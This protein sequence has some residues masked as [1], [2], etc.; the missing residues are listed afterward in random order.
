MTT[1]VPLIIK[2]ETP[3]I[4]PITISP[5]PLSDYSLEPGEKLTLVFEVSDPQNLE[6]IIAVN[7]GAAKAFATT[8]I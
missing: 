8:E 1:S 6:I 3:L 4:L 7:A 5:K 2:I